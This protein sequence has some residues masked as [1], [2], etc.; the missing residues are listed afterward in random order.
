MKAFF[1]SI[2]SIIVFTVSF[3]NSLI[4]LDYHINRDFYETHCV[5]KDKPDLECHGKC[6]AK[7]NTE[8]A[9]S[10][11][12]IIK[13]GTFEFVFIASSHYQIPCPQKELVSNN[14]FKF[15]YKNKILPNDFTEILPDPPQI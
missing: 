10:P 2:L 9:N 8:K 6:E 13:T 11:F 4:L 1:C 14:N 5:N 12:Q 7:K 15:I 3:Q